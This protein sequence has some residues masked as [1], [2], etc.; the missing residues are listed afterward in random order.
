MVRGL[1]FAENHSLAADNI[2]VST[3]DDKKVLIWSVQSLKD[4][5]SKHRL[6]HAT[7]TPKS[8]T[9][10]ATYLSKHMVLST[11]HSYSADLFATSGSVVQVW[12][13]ERS[14]PI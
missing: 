12:N 11:D 6:A 3:G 13:Y 14:A 4:Q 7:G 1:A 8:Y 9:P 10:Q 2:F 5:L